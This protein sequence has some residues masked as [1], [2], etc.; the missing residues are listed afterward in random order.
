MELL[1]GFFRDGGM[2]I[3]L[4]LGVSIIGMAI[5]V[6]R[7][8]HLVFR[9]SIDTKGLWE[10]VSKCIRERDFQKAHSFCVGSKAPVPRVF[11]A[12]LSSYKEGERG[13]QHAVDEVSMEIMPEIEKR[14]PYLSLAA[15]IAT[16]LGLLGTIHGLIQAFSAVGNAD[17][18]QKAA[19][20]A[21]G[22][23]IALYTTAFGLFVAIPLLVSYT[24][25][26][27]KAHRLID[28]IDEYSVKLMNL[29]I[30]NPPTEYKS[31]SQTD[32]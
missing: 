26:L 17:P 23:S 30:H 18:S 7:V 19:L 24:I 14:V 11:E 1:A 25:L 32:E 6:E 31:G 27:S 21:S 28:E 29:L 22:I 2:F 13:V 4:I 16:L 20:L 5:V 12:A 9:Y 10:K 15:N 8:M 3:Y